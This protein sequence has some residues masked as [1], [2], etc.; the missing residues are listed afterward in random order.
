[1]TYRQTQL[2]R[3]ALKVE[4]GKQELA[5]ELKRGL[6]MLRYLGRCQCGLMLTGRDRN[7]NKNTYLCPHCG[8]SGPL[9]AIS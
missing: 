4:R 1:M 3:H 6:L 9:A 7:H 5:E 8:A 2:Q